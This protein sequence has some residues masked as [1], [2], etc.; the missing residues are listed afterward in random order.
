V[1]LE[2]ATK[3][4]LYLGLLLAIGVVSAYWCVLRR[5]ALDSDAAWQTDA[6]SR[7]RVIGLCASSIAVTAL[8]GRAW[9]HTASAFG[10]ADA[11]S[12]NALRTIVVQSRWG[13]GWRWQL[14]SAL[15]CAGLFGLA[16]GSSRAVWAAVACAV[17]AFAW[18][19]AM[20]G[21]ASGAVG[22][23]MLH[24]AHVLAGGLWLG[25][26]AS[27]M[28]I[29]R[30]SDVARR[31]ALFTSFDVLALP[32]A[33]IA[34]AT[35][36]AASFLYLGSTSNVFT[37]VYGRVLML[38]VALVAVATACGYVNWRSIRAGSGEPGRAGSIE[39]LA[40]LSIVVVTSLLTELE[41]P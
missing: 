8:A 20:T 19:V 28:V 26:L 39:L 35:G 15:G 30:I 23:M 17:V 38:K 14:V 2:S 33:A 11:W 22:R 13:L 24:T 1:T 3:V 32:G 41:H 5:A 16:A 21:H 40:A 4:G 6:E 37:T 12:L 31:R 9:A 10:F 18:T 36:I 25:T 34:V 7:L 29:G 27:L